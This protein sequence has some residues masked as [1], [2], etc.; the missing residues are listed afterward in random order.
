MEILRKTFNKDSKIKISKLENEQN[1]QNKNSKT[2]NQNSNTAAESFNKD[3]SIKKENNLNKNY[4]KMQNLENKDLQGNND[5]FNNS[6][7]DD[8]FNKDLENLKKFSKLKNSLNSQNLEEKN[9]YLLNELKNSNNFKEDK[10]TKNLKE[11]SRLFGDPKV[12][13]N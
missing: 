3:L 6:N 4:Y 12:E 5:S 9:K 8:E 13:E 11:L 1:L 10:E 2:I 7:L